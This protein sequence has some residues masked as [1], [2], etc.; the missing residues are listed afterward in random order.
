MGRQLIGNTNV[1]LSQLYSQC[2]RQ[3][4]NAPLNFTRTVSGTGPYHGSTYTVPQNLSLCL[5][6]QYRNPSAPSGTPAYPWVNGALNSANDFSVNSL[7]LNNYLF[8]QTFKFA[9]TANGTMTITWPNS[10]DYPYDYAYRSTNTNNGEIGFPYQ[11]FQTSTSYFTLSYTA[12]LGYQL[13]GYYTAKIGGTLITSSTSFNFT[14][15]GASYGS[16]S[17]GRWW[18]RTESSVSLTSFL[19]GN[20]S[21]FSSDMCTTLS[22]NNTYYHDGIGTFPA[23][24][25]IVYTD[26]AGTS[27]LNGGT[28]MNW[29]WFPAGPNPPSGWFRVLGS[30]GTVQSTSICP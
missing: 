2:W 16:S 14:Y 12:N 19:V 9:G 13:D 17:Q 15:N 24:G 8:F 7:P 20:P 25:D 10:G 6:S 5:F 30:T 22:S 27:P 4:Q 21:A 3:L 28:G 23:T 18:A 29:P 1:K 26:S 11:F